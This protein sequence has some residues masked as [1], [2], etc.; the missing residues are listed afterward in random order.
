MNWF[1][2][3][4]T[5]VSASVILASSLMLAACSGAKDNGGGRQSDSPS[6]DVKAASSLAPYEINIYIPG[7]M[8]K[9]V[10]TVEQAIN[11]YL[12]DKINATVKLNF[13]EWAN[14]TTKTNLMITSGEKFDLMY[15]ANSYGFANE[16]AKGTY[17]QLDDLI[18]KYGQ[19][20]LKNLAPV[21]VKGS[22]INGK[23][24]GVPSNKEYAAS[25]TLLVRKDLMQKYNLDPSKIKT[26]H[27]FTDWF[28][29]IK[30]GEPNITPFAGVGDG[31]S[32]MASLFELFNGDYFGVLDKS[33]NDLKV[34]DA[35]SNPKYLEALHQLRDWYNAGYIIK[36]AATTQVTRDEYMKN[37][38][39][40]S[41]MV[42]SKPG[43][44]KEKSLTTGMDLQQVDFSEPYS[45]TADVTGA[46]LAVSRTSADP[47]RVVKFLNLLY[48]DK[49]LLNMID[50][51][52]EGKH[53]VKV[54][55]NVI[56]FPPGLNSQTV[57]YSAQ[58]DQWIFGNQFNSYVLK[59]EDPH[60]WDKFK[61]F[62]DSAKVSKAMGFIFDPTPVQ[63]EINACAIIYNQYRAGLLS[64]SLDLDKNL[65]VMVEKLKSN[66]LDKIIAE[67][68]KQLDKWAQTNANK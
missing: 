15:T 47:E 2:L 29:V 14:Y 10:G 8:S 55:D 38:K 59:T 50:W 28:K 7:K 1:K 65:P 54:S 48:S 57:G 34:I 22:K 42:S 33:A 9:E 45:T 63:N 19:D 5:K 25:Q 27:D 18:A 64:G 53:Y 37:G 40:F 31:S 49:T 11:A 67:K 24:Y 20:I 32:I 4:G 30:D 16:V 17:L 39:V 36:D 12:K 61:Q 51:G 43:I 6:G 41:F 3:R 60:K 52:I 13:T 62:N 66:G 44:D 23:M 56:D 21:Y 58:G 35:F 26:Y 68:Q 46:I